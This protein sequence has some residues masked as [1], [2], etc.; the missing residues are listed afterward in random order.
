[1]CVIGILNYFRLYYTTFVT[2][3]NM[4]SLLDLPPEILEQIGVYIGPSS[5]LLNMVCTYLRGMFSQ[6]ESSTIFDMILET[7]NPDMYLLWINLHAKHYRCDLFWFREKNCIRV[8]KCAVKRFPEVLHDRSMCPSLAEV[9][10][11]CCDLEYIKYL[12]ENYILKNKMNLS[13]FSI[14]ENAAFNGHIS[15]LKYLRPYVRLGEQ[16]LMSA[17]KGDFIDC[18]LYIIKHYPGSIPKEVVEVS[19]QHGSIKCLRYFI[20]TRFFDYDVKTVFESASRSGSLECMK[21]VSKNRYIKY[22]DTY[23]NNALLTGSVDCLAYLCCKSGWNFDISEVCKRAI[24]FDRLDCLKYIVESVPASYRRILPSNCCLHAADKMVTAYLE[25]IR[26]Y[27]CSWTKKSYHTANCTKSLVCFEY[28][29]KNGCP[30]NREK[31]CRALAN[32]YYKPITDYF[33]TYM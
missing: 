8:I 15:I 14:A 20:K 19:A 33:N 17:I 12:F 30:Y 28:L 1:M 29:H 6:C 13:Q 11:F 26:K 9:A 4:A 5:G 31:L 21:Y 32:F 23:I 16:C 25:C 24:I 2:I 7:D 18:V 22:Y 3:T 10:A 27:G